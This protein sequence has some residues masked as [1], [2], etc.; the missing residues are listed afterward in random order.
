MHAVTLERTNVLALRL[1]LEIERRLEALARKTGR[2]KTFYVREAILR[3]VED[4]EDYH[5]ARQR[6]APGRQRVT[7]EELERGLA[8][9]SNESPRR[10]RPA[11]A[12]SLRKSRRARGD[13]APR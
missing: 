4:P 13:K 5:L 11:R 2:T 8:A 9:T 1:P 3:Y 7:L 6:L 10:T 12:G